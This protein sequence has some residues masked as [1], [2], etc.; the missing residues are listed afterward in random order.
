MPSKYVYTEIDGRRLRLSNLEKTIYPNAILSKAEVI[1]YYL[2]IAPL[3]L[4]YSRL[5]PT[6]LIRF[7]DGIGG[8][9]F[10]SKSAPDW[11][12]D[13]IKRVSI[14]HSKENVEYIVLSEKA[15]LV[16]VAN[17]SGLEIHPAQMLYNQL[18]TPDHFIFDL[19]PSENHSFEDIKKIAFDLKS[20][21]EKYNYSPLVKTSGSRGIHIYVPIIKKYNH[22]Q[23]TESC[24]LLAQEFVN[25]NKE[26]CTLHLNKAKRKGKLLIDIFRN[27]KSHTTVAPFSLRAKVNA[28]IS[29]PLSWEQLEKINDS[30]HYNISNYRDL[31]DSQGD[32]WET[33]ESLRAELHNHLSKEVRPSITAIPPALADYASK[34]D[35][36]LSNEPLPE[37]DEEIGNR[38]VVQLH[39][40]T[41]LHYDLRLEK[42][43]SLL[44]WAIPKGLPIEEYEK[45]LAIRTEDHPIKYLK[46]EGIIPEGNY[47][48]GEMWVFNSGN[49]E[50]IKISDSSYKFELKGDLFSGKFKIYNT[51]DDQWIVERIENFIE[52]S[53]NKPSHMLAQSTK[54]LKKSSR[55]SY[56]I[57]W[58]GIRVFLIKNEDQVNV[59]SRNG[60]DISS[61]FPDVIESVIEK[62]KLHRCILDAELVC[63]DEQGRP[64]FSKIISRMHTQGAQ[65]VL[66]A[67]KLNPAI[68]Y[69]FDLLDMDGID[70]CK[71]PLYRRQSMLRG[72]VKTSNLMRLSEV[73]EDGVMLLEAA[74]KMKLEGIMV[75]DKNAKYYKGQRSDAWLKYKFREI[76]SCRIIGYTEGK[77]DRKELFGSLHLV[78]KEND[79]ISY[80]GRVGSGFDTKKMKMLLKKLEPLVIKYKPIEEKVEEE[81]RTTWVKDELLC[82]IQYA[83]LTEN[84]TFREPIFIELIE[85]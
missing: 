82:K 37:A 33:W 48:A 9:S 58:D 41:N 22:E 2:D 14:E 30:R 12:P 81:S 80:K 78:T 28:P 85:E 76:E 34:R 67:S 25:R 24:K 8:Q 15:D 16:W 19:D 65:S 55:F 69:V 57:K 51:K 29:M 32:A 71:L 6:T 26:V 18:E 3:F 75:K 31:L 60:R 40:A 1:Q 62:V 54:G 77:G 10:Y 20:F 63:L 66:R 59:I 52:F 7:P 13:W 64:I 49:F 5:R 74:R 27:H 47:G 11:T 39:D 84:G 42:E 23:M 83:S 53:N 68:S 73:F 17:I 61:E 46:F 70:I 56:E 36:N 35:F 44:S 72:I 43:G 45:R 38:F 21:L 79:K 4:K 50:F